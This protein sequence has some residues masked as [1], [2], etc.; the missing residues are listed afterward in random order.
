[1]PE[2]QLGCFL[3][4]GFSP[5][6][7]HGPGLTHLVDRDFGGHGDDQGRLQASQGTGIL[8]GIDDE[9]CQRLA[10]TD[11]VFLQV[12]L[13]R[14]H[15]GGRKRETAA[16][17]VD[18]DIHVDPPGRVIGQVVQRDRCPAR[19]GP[20]GSRGRRRDRSTAAWNWDRANRLLYT[21]TASD[22]SAFW[23]A[24][25]ARCSRNSPGPGPPSR[26]GTTASTL[27]G[28]V[29]MLPPGAGTEVDGLVTGGR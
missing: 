2:V 4:Q 17:G 15:P 6:T 18:W 19:T 26:T 22:S 12:R 27:S 3:L 21:M 25:T 5:S 8:A 10:D 20:V 28:P 24:V 14:V 7:R 11:I 23:L 9:R 13:H 29:A 1:M 16:R